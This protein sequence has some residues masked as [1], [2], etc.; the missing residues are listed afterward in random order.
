M[1]NFNKPVCKITICV[2]VK[3]L[4]EA[5]CRKPTASAVGMW[6]NPIQ[7]YRGCAL[8]VEGSMLSVERKFSQP[9]TLLTQRYA[10]HL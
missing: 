10:R 8:K 1:K 4:K 6:R 3:S 5:S 9:S 7:P 2:A